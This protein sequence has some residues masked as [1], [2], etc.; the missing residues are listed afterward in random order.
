M[1]DI[2]DKQKEF[3]EDSKDKNKW[4]SA[5]VRCGKTLS[6]RISLYRLLTKKFEKGR[7][8]GG[9]VYLFAKKRK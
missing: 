3:M 1:I 4:A 2:S 6:L 5:P 9:Q 8:Y 7:D